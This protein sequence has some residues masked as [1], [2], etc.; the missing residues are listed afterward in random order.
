MPFINDELYG[1]AAVSDGLGGKPAPATL[2]KWRGAG[3]GPKF[4]RVGRTP[5][6]RGADINAWLASRTV[7]HTITTPAPHRQSKPPSVRPRRQSP[8]EQ[9]G[10]NRPAA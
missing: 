2:A 9:D 8:R 6:Y 10:P 5:L 4:V 1:A 3:D 7:S